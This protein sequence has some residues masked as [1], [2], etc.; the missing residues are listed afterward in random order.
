MFLSHA[1]NSFPR[2]TKI[3]PK[4]LCCRA[5]DFRPCI[6]ETHDEWIH[7]NASSR[8]L[9]FRL[10]CIVGGMTITSAHASVPN[11]SVLRSMYSCSKNSDIAPSCLRG[12]VGRRRHLQ[13]SPMKQTCPTRLNVRMVI[14]RNRHTSRTPCVPS[15]LFPRTNEAGE[16]A[17]VKSCLFPH[18][19]R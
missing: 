6:Q 8:I 3:A 11:Q 9:R 5:T 16:P 1:P 18:D 10:G 19:K 17:V 2:W 4:T 12:V 7:F 14:P 13:K 15:V